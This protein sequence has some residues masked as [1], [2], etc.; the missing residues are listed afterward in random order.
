MTPETV[1]KSTSLLPSSFDPTP[2]RR[3]RSNFST[4]EE[5]WMM[6]FSFFSWYALKKAARSSGRSFVRMPA[7]CR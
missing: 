5:P 4:P 2:M 6:F 3:S 1:W 7:A